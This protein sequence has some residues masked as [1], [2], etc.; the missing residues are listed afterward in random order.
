MKYVI[1]AFLLVSSQCK[2]LEFKGIEIGSVYTD[3][4]I[5]LLFKEAGCAP[6]YSKAS[7]RICK[8]SV[9]YY[10]IRTTANVNKNINNVVTSISLNIPKSSLDGIEEI[11]TNKHGT[12]NPKRGTPNTSLF[13]I[14][15]ARKAPY[16]K[17][18]TRHEKC[19]KWTN[20]QGVDIEF[21]EPYQ[22]SGA[23]DSITIIYR[24]TDNPTLDPTDD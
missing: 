9:S 16:Q 2:A 17:L 6:T 5:K 24:I 10:G 14:H 21:C 15:E 7:D 4:N 12:P 8:I 3:Q 13:T 1:P 23:S 19:S 20:V 11:L 22:Y 18:V